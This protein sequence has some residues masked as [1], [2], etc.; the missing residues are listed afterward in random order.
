MTGFPRPSGEITVETQG[1]SVIWSTKVGL[2]AWASGHR[3]LMV[4]SSPSPFPR[5]SPHTGRDA[6]IHA[7]EK[8]PWA[9]RKFRQCL[10]ILFLPS[11]QHR[12]DTWTPEPH[13]PYARH[14]RVVRT[15]PLVRLQCTDGV[16]DRRAGSWRHPERLLPAQ[17]SQ[18]SPSRKTDCTANAV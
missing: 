15:G 10:Y 4:V 13:R 14:A 8:S 3:V 5:S 12:M 9:R 16:A 2:S 18:V 7:V 11:P 1:L 17:C 6:G